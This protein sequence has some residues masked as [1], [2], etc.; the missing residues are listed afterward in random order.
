[1]IPPETQFPTFAPEIYGR[2]ALNEL[3]TYAV[4]FLSESGGEINAEA[5]QTTPRGVGGLPTMTGCPRHSGWSRCSTA[6]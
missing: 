4:Y 6:A 5:A 3:V 1:M 2:I